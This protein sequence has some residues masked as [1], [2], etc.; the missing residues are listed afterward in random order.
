[1]YLEKERDA[2]FNA[3]LLMSTDKVAGSV[4]KFS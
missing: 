2:R 3:I 4:L 1:M